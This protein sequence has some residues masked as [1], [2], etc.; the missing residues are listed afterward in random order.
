MSKRAPT[1]LAARTAPIHLRVPLEAL[2]D[3]QEGHLW[4]LSHSTSINRSAPPTASLCQ[5][6]SIHWSCF[7]VSKEHQSLLG[8]T[9][10]QG[11]HRP[12]CS[13][14][15]SPNCSTHSRAALTAWHSKG[16]T[17]ELEKFKL[18]ASGFCHCNRIKQS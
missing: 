7:A 5:Y 1:A 11:R 9:Q 2:V 12:T 3:S 8:T 17:Q 15:G 18:L 10:K 14:E 16:R 6:L 13:P 4:S